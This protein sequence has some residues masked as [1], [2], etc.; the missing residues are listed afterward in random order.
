M[1]DEDAVDPRALNKV[2]VALS[3]GIPLRRIIP[4]KL[5]KILKG[6][7]W[8]LLAIFVCWSIISVVIL[9][10]VTVDNPHIDLI[11]SGWVIILFLLLM[12]RCGYQILYLITYYYN[13]D[14]KHVIIRKG[15]IERAELTLPW[16]KITDVFVDQDAWDVVLC[17]Y[18]VHISS[19][20]IA[21][22]EFAHLDGVTKKGA[23]LLRKLIL[24]KIQK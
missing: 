17:L 12:W 16:D 11:W 13:V 2:K 21:S 18:D 9:R 10:F 22:G 19:P 8:S 7:F 23:Y 24:E 15:V 5:R 3:K 14:D 4:I 1:A 20:T 6:C